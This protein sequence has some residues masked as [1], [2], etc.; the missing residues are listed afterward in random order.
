[1][2]QAAA[3]AA[4]PKTEVDYSDMAEPLSLR[5]SKLEDHVDTLENT[6]AMKVAPSSTI[7]PA[8]VGALTPAP[9]TG[10]TL[11]S[12]HGRGQVLDLRTLTENV[13]EKKAEIAA[14]QEESDA[15]IADLAGQLDKEV[16]GP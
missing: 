12:G 4:T 10:L 2:K 7:V 8:H 5:V 1:M 11:N 6:L 16:R 3:D 13:A 9:H 15:K 14:F